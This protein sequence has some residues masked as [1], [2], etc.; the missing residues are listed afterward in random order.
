MKNAQK[1]Y[2]RKCMERDEMIHI[3]LDIFEGR[4][5]ELSMNL[6]KLLS[7]EQIKNFIEKDLE[8]ED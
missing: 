5:V 7:T 4:E 8:L 2:W 3:L 6:L 1:K